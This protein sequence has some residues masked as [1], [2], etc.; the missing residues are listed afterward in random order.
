VLSPQ[1]EDAIDEVPVDPVRAVVRTP[2]F[3]PKPLYAFFSVVSAPVAECPLG[4]PEKPADLLGPNAL[5]EMLLD[6]V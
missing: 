5:L 4:D 6:G 1:L 3:V 2:G